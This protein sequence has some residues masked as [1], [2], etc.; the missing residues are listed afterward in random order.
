[1]MAL[2]DDGNWQLVISSAAIHRHPGNTSMQNYAGSSKSP[3][4]PNNCLRTV[5]GQN[6]ALPIIRNIP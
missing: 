2:I 1:M 4:S 3:K 5:Y 6:P